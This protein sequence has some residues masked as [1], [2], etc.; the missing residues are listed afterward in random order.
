ML[1]MTDPKFTPSDVHA[2]VHAWV[3]QVPTLGAMDDWLFRV[4]VDD[5]AQYVT[6]WLTYTADAKIREYREDISYA[7]IHDM[8]NR[9]GSPLIVLDNWFTALCEKFKVSVPRF[10]DR[11]V[12]RV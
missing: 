12:R 10:P 2:D 11:P 5:A 3:R 8:A 4:E 9:F 1:T 6:G 7:L